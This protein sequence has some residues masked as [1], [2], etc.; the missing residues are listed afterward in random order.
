MSTINHLDVFN[1]KI[2][3]IKDR[4]RGCVHRKATGV[5]LYGRPGT[6][7]TYTVRNTL[8]TLAIKYAYSNGHLTPIGLF[9]LIAENSNRI[10]RHRRHQ[11]DLQRPHQPP[12]VLAAL[13]NGHDGSGT[14]QVRY[15]TAKGDREVSFDGAIIGISNLALDGHHSDVL[16]ALKDRIHI[17]HY[18]PTDLEIIALCRKIASDGLGGIKPDKCQMVLNYLLKELESHELRPSVRLYIDKAMKDYDCG[19]PGN[20]RPIGRISSGTRS[21]NNWSN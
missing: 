18:E 16:R 21:S 14:R 8:D 2:T 20:P 4:V 5:Y 15:K 17:C 7:K 1:R 9:D 12:V 13:G 3:V 19:R 11:L 6:S 10:N